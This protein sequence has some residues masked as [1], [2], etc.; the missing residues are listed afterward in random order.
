MTVNLMLVFKMASGFAKL[1]NDPKAGFSSNP[2]NLKH[3][4]LF[5]SLQGV[6]KCDINI[7]R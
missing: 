4:K 2:S 3:T 6:I 7:L 5:I 1:L